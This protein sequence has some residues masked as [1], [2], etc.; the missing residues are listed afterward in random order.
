MTHSILFANIWMQNTK[1]PPKSCDF[2]AVSKW[3][4]KTL[5]DF[6]VLHKKSAG[7]KSLS[8]FAVSDEVYL[9]YTVDKHVWYA[10]YKWRDFLMIIKHDGWLLLFTSF[11]PQGRLREYLIWLP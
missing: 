11:P 6:H 2:E 3:C 7:L 9:A 8:I 10:V 4:I 5:C 1:H